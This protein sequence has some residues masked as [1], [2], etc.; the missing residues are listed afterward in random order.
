MDIVKALHQR[1]AVLQGELDKIQRA[2]RALSGTITGGVRNS[3][4]KFRHTATNKRK[5]RAAQQKIWAA[6]HKR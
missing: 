6:K 1:R 4:R 5:L 2:I 3:G